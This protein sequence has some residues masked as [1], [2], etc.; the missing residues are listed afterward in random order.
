MT[1]ISLN[2]F[3]LH[4]GQPALRGHV[5]SARGPCGPDVRASI[6]ASNEKLGAL[7]AD[8]VAG[9]V[10]KGRKI[11]DTPVIVDTAPTLYINMN[12]VQK[13][14]VQVPVELLGSANLI[15]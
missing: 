7:L 13:L 10:L 12:S 15:Q 5:W 9:V 1:R 4:G 14:G 6:D 2:V 3:L 11:A 8:A